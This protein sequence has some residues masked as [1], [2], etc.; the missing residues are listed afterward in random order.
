MKI[1]NSPT[2]EAQGHELRMHPA[3]AWTPSR[4]ATQSTISVLFDR[5][6][7]AKVGP[8]DPGV[9]L[10][11][12]PSAFSA[13][14]RAGL[15]P[16]S[17]L[18]FFTD[19]DHARCVAATIRAVR[20][21]D[22]AVLDVDLPPSTKILGRQVAFYIGSITHRLIRT[23]RRYPARV[24]GKDGTWR[25]VREAKELLEVLFPR[26]LE[27]GLAHRVSGRP[28]PFRR[29]YAWLMRLVLLRSRRTGPWLFTPPGKLKL[30]YSQAIEQ[31]GVRLGQ[32]SP[33][34]GTV[35]DYQDLL[36]VLLGRSKRFR[37]APVEQDD[38]RLQDT[39]AVLNGLESAFSD[40]HVRTGWRLYL[41]YLRAN[42]PVTL[43]LAQAGESLIRG[44]NA[45]GAASYEGNG[46]ASAALFEAARRAGRETIVL[47]HNC[48]SLTN[49]TIADAVIS[50]LYR[51][52][53]HTELTTTTV[54]WSPDDALVAQRMA[55]ALEFTPRELRLRTPSAT[56]GR[57]HER[58][59]ILHAG[60]YQN[61]SDFFPWVAETSDEFVRHVRELSSA[62][63]E[64][65]DVD[66]TIRIR[67]KAEVDVD[68]IRECIVPA[69]NVT[70]CSTDED[71]L[72]QLTQSDLLVC[73][74]STTVM[75]ALQMGK[76]VLLWGS[77]RR[78]KQIEA[79][80][81][82]PAEDGRA[83]VYAVENGRDLRSMILA[84][85]D[86]HQG[87]PLRHDEIV[88]YCFG[89]DALDL[90]EIA[91]RLMAKAV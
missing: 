69:D 44:V 58:F 31:S 42:L 77:T 21:F 10:C 35:T 89:S 50:T 78:F 86:Q 80:S 55:G 64:I 83:A 63:A 22:A 20:E 88:R 43:G 18:D 91:R 60:N 68:V 56:H 28:P 4:A 39:D 53:K 29:F 47:N 25:E 70:V 32:V 12:T 38:P 5:E 17:S 49:S 2:M 36:R 52:R 30:G 65:P 51:Q 87:C 66:L 3:Q 13:A 57:S 37:V 24:R 8:T 27:H 81:T 84:I 79:R 72:K 41:P 7:L 61:W 62:V 85:R 73:F 90:S 34:T 15:Q 6:D 16:Q 26:I 40:P 11:L 48:H 23:V 9:V 75:Q 67:P 59:R 82:P 14:V 74:F 33:T 46:W 19:R 1:I 71:F 54:H 45:I 76:P